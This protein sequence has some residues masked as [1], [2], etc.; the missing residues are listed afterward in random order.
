MKSAYPPSANWCGRLL[1]F[2]FIFREQHEYCSRQVQCYGFGSQLVDADS[3]LFLI[4]PRSFEMPQLPAKPLLFLSRKDNASNF[5][6]QIGVIFWTLVISC[7]A[8][9]TPPLCALD[10]AAG[11]RRRCVR[12][13]RYVVYHKMTAHAAQHGKCYSSGLLC[14]CV[15]VLGVWEEGDMTTPYD[16]EGRRDATYMP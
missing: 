13:S 12:I 6:G 15:I 9:R 10:S 1:H 2:D 16:F 4:P 11:S 7:R 8:R 3:T 14:A 5:G